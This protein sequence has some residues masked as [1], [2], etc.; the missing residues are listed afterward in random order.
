MKADVLFQECWDTCFG[1]FALFTGE[2][3][4][5]QNI[6]QVII[7]YFSIIPSTFP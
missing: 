2:S 4:I 5:S 3:R 1:I 7:W 6:K